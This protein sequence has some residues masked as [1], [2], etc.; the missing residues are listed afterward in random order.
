MK[1]FSAVFVT[2]GGFPGK[3]FLAHKIKVLY[4]RNKNVSEAR[5]TQYSA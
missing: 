4:Y 3:Y 2:Q 5:V 1:T